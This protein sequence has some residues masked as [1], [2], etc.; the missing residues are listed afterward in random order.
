L[1]ANTLHTWNVRG[2]HIQTLTN[3]FIQEGELCWVS[4]DGADQAAVLASRVIS[5]PSSRNVTP[6][7]FRQLI[8]S[9]QPPPVLR[10]RH[11]ELEHHE[12]RRVLRERALHAHRSMPHRRKH[13]LDCV[14]SVQ[15]REMLGGKVEDRRRPV[16]ASKMVFGA[17]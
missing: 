17:S 1:V 12:A 3:R 16:R 9:F 2:G 8:S 14:R 4:G 11:H 15:M 5:I 7:D 13:A 6:Y 10:S